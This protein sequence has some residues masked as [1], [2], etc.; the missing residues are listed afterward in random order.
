V[1]EKLSHFSITGVLSPPE[2]GAGEHDIDLLFLRGNHSNNPVRAQ[3]GVK[4]GDRARD[5]LAK[6][7][8]IREKVGGRD[9]DRTGDPLLA[10][11]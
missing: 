9:R 3:L 5:E 1:T 10:K 2:A 6:C 7:F 4:S 11:Q 8:A